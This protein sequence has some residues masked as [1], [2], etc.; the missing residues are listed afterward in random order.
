MKWQLKL[1]AVIWLLSGISGAGF[2]ISRLYL[3]Q[4]WAI[5]ET[6]FNTC[7]IIGCVCFVTLIAMLFVRDE[8][9]AGP[10]KSVFRPWFRIGISLLITG[11]LF[12][13]ERWTGAGI[14]LI[15][16]LSNLAI[17]SLAFG[18]KRAMVTWKMQKE[19]RQ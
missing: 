7:A 6:L 1:L 9:F 5:N 12:K 16:S 8:S 19:I 17:L 10:V 18:I 14:I 15:L 13:I 4:H 3:I 11:I 2:F